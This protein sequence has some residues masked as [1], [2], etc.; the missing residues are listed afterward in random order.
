MKANVYKGGSHCIR[1]MIWKDTDNGPTHQTSGSVPLYPDGKR[2]TEEEG[3]IKVLRILKRQGVKAYWDRDKVTHHRIE[4]DTVYLH[5]YHGR[6]DPDEDME[7]FGTEGPL[8]GPFETVQFTY[9]NQIRCI[10]A[11]GEEKWLNWDDNQ[12][13]LHE[14][15]Y[16][17]DCSFHSNKDSA[18]VGLG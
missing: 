10:S 3:R 12:L 4:P 6:L 11:D 13:I 16:Y 7:G 17:G 9:A 1:Y 5:L 18:F 2:I 14:G 15:V 8:L